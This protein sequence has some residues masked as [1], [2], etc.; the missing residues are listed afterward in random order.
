MAAEDLHHPPLRE[1]PIS[2]TARSLNVDQR[3]A[4]VSGVNTGI[5]FDEEDHHSCMSNASNDN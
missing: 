1:P 3:R 4:D 2:N 5:P